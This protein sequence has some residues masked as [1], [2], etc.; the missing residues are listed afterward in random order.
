MQRTE[1]TI[2]AIV[3][4]LF[5]AVL[6][7]GANIYLGLKI[8][9]T[10]SASIPASI[11]A[12]GVLKMF[13][14]Y[15]VLENNISQTIATTGEALAGM[16]IFV[17]PA[18]LI[19]HTWHEFNY[20][21]I[22]VMAICGGFI[23][24]AFSVVLRKTLLNNP[25]LT[26]PEGQA[27]GQVLLTASNPKASKANFIAL[28]SGMTISAIL[29]F[30]QTGLQIFADSYMKLMKVGKAA[31]GGGVSFSV[32]IIGAGFLVGP[33]PT[34]VAFIASCVGWLIFLPI[35]ISVYGFKDPANLHASVFALWT[36]H[37]RP[38]GI[39]VLI[40]SGFATMA[41]L[42]KPIFNGIRESTKAFRNMGHVEANDRDLG[43]TILTIVVI[44]SSLPVLY[45][46]YTQLSQ[47][48][49]YNNLCNILLAIVILLLVLIVGFFIASV[50][51]YFAGFIGSTNSPGSGLLFIAV[52][53][54]SLFLR[55][56]INVHEGEH[57]NIL[58][59]TIII[60]VGFISFASIITNENS[61]DF[62][63]GQIVGAS[64]YKQQISLFF[65]IIA[66][67]F[68]M[69]LMMDLIFQ[70]YGIAGIVPHPGIDP[71]TTLSA[72]QA[73]AIAMVTQNIIARS[74]D[75][76]L[77][78]YGL[79][80]GFICLIIDKILIRYFKK[81]CPGLSVGFG[82]YLA[83]PL[84]TSLFIGGLLRYFVSKR[85][86]RLK[87]EH[88]EESYQKSKNIT[89]LLVCGLVAGES[90]MGLF[91]S[92]PFVIKQSSDAFR[93]VS[94]NFLGISQILSAIITLLVLMLVYKV[95]G[96]K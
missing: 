16:A 7:G 69:P 51:G 71:N 42:A 90:L 59:A 80:I 1:L 53:A 50:A 86:R 3:I 31:V 9:N 66:T 22:V 63:S 83:P 88:G 23:G 39:G 79:T 12:M 84:I 72:P 75:W 48:T 15:S 64:P 45:F 94:D 27:I 4:G 70:A 68:T 37:V 56:L 43:F 20:W 92:I 49:D 52:I 62:K 77:I 78:G 25:A 26:F 57:L 40:F 13:K 17:F 55:P 2:K 18:L 54:L 65:G 47:M 10:I 24:I 60:L 30:C 28:S 34:I 46:I 29:N 35:F 67:A 6:L 44:L 21:Q 74:Q 96:R 89:N 58:F 38:I 87:E 5:L 73:T 82:L 81:R 61:Q 85:Q 33:N 32:A 36:S 11:L 93:I 76:S 14:N 91:I 95:A 41:E 19:L 8:G